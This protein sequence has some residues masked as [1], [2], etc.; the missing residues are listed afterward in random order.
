MEKGL[1]R[2]KTV[3][4]LAHVRREGDAFILHDLDE[5]LRGIGK[6]AEAY[7]Q[8]FGSGGAENCPTHSP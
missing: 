6:L 1:E 7:T 8:V 5:H 4:Y 2:E 3:R